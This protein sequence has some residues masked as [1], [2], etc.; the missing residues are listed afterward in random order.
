MHGLILA[1]GEGSRLA[2][3]GV[4]APKALVPVRGVPQLLRLARALERAGAES[5]TCL[6]RRGVSLDPVAA[7]LARLRPPLRVH[8]CLTLSSLHT[9]VEGLAL[10]PPG[11]VFCTMVDTVMP[12]ADW[13]RVWSEA[14]TRLH[15]GA[16]AALVV[17]PFVDDERPLYVARDAEGRV[18]RVTDAPVPIPLVTGGVYAFG[19]R[20]RD[21][22]AVALAAGHERMRKFLRLLVEDGHD[23]RAIEV[24][25]IIDLDHRRDLDVANAWQESCDEGESSSA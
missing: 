25:Q 23:V 19:P 24:R 13:A 14:R 18:T 11:E 6:V 4:T 16:D 5:L 20:A 22:A 1:G 17:T 9:L 7:D 3:S 15:T 21:A 12:G 10:I 8:D 2:A